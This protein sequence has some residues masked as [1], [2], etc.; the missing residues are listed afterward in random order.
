M[1]KKIVVF[2]MLLA[3]IVT[4]LAPTQIA[5]AANTVKAPTIKVALNTDGVPVVTWK[6]VSGATGYRVYRKTSTDT[7]WVKVNTTSKTEV[8]DIACEAKAESTVKY[9]VKTYVKADGKTTW[10]ANSKA[11]SV[12]LP[13]ASKVKAPT[14]NVALNADGVPVVTWK[15][16]SGATG[17]RVYRKISTDTKWVKVSTTSKTKVIDTDCKAKAGSTVQYRVKTYVKADEKTTWSANSKALSV[18][19]SAKAEYTYGIEGSNYCTY[20]N[21]K[22]IVKEFYDIPSEFLDENTTLQDL[23]DAGLAYS[24]YYYYDDKYE[25][26]YSGANYTCY[27]YVVLSD[28]TREEIGVY[29][30]FCFP[31][32]FSPNSTDRS[33]YLNYED[34]LSEFEKFRKSFLAGEL[35]TAY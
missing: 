17:Y 31:F 32:S 28:R 20:L 23:Q 6:K 34:S 22:V 24:T 27:V 21:N 30:N 15:K 16:V 9:R 4:T 14:I 35:E 7:K 25:Y 10:S 2:A 5:Q 11:I 8:V 13:A 29:D 19:L 1:N 18:K 3:L 12:K 33:S 26:E